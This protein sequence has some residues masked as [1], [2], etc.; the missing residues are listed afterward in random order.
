[1]AAHA[2][3]IQAVPIADRA[4]RRGQSAAPVMYDL[5]FVTSS[6]T[7]TPTLASLQPAAPPLDITPPTIEHV[8]KE[9]LPAPA[10]STVARDKDDRPVAAA[11]PDSTATPPPAA[12]PAADPPNTP[13]EP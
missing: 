4:M 13:Q 6:A 11:E 7:L 10:G 3:P 12:A 9:E 8:T 5:R 2:A 1:M